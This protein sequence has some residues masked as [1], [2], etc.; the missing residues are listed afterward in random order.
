M[1][2]IGLNLTVIPTVRF[3]AIT[4]QISTSTKTTTTRTTTK[5]KKE[6]NKLSYHV[7]SCKESKQSSRILTAL[8]FIEYSVPVVQLKPYLS[9]KGPTAP[10][11]T[12]LV[13]VSKDGTMY[14]H[15]HD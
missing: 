2:Q 9:V 10:I 6:G 4:T 12:I 11:I 5:R 15:H 1:A 7:C 8:L 3:K 14:Y 13:V